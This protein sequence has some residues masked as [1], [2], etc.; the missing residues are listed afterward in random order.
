[1]AGNPHILKRAPR[2]FAR[3]CWRHKILTV[4]AVVLIALSITPII[5]II[6]RAWFIVHTDRRP[7]AGHAVPILEV[8]TEGFTCGV[9]AISTVYR[10]HGLDP[11]EGERVRWRL[12]VDTKAVFYVS[13]STCALHPDVYMVLAQ[14]YFAIEALDME[15]DDAF[16]VL[17]DHV[18]D[19][20]GGMAVL[21]IRRRSNG[22]LHWVTATHAE[23]GKLLVYDSLLQEPIHE[24]PDYVA[25]HVVSA[26]M[27]RPTA[28]GRMPMSS[29]A[30]HRAGS[31]ELKR[32]VKRI[33]ALKAGPQEP[34]N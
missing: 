20:S 29:I 27:V 19:N 6:T 23:A 4:L 3:F 32:A 24:G 10:A 13:D 22:H 9:H 8:Q 15:R 28:D 5:I 21:L 30:A 25:D 16:E 11:D 17:H 33:N 14:D 18:A 7:V 31:A 34:T 2:A 26:L 12:G 1:M